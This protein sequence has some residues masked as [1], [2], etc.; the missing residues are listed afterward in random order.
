MRDQLNIVEED[1]NLQKNIEKALLEEEEEEEEEVQQGS[2]DE[3]LLEME[4]ESQEESQEEESQT[5]Q[6]DEFIQ[7]ETEQV[8]SQFLK[9]EIPK[10]VFKNAIEAQ[11][12]PLLA[13]SFLE[14]SYQ[15]NNAFVEKFILDYI[16]EH[17]GD[18][19]FRFQW[20]IDL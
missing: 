12:D 11:K 1:S 19:F 7:S 20:M 4:E 2:D 5:N 15:L 16:L 6:V 8:Q 10:V 18:V 9:G 17:F 3:D 14:I 13:L